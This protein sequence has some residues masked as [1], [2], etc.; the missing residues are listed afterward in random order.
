MEE[1]ENE[2]ELHELDL[3]SEDELVMPPE[4]EEKQE[5]EKKEESSD[6]DQWI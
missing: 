6:S 4:E 2:V 3:V 1:D 5:E